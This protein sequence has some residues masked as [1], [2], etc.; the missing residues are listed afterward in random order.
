MSASS[1]SCSA[2]AKLVRSRATD[3]AYVDMRYGNGFAVGWKG[4]HAA[5]RRPVANTGESSHL[6]G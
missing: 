3:I 4:A 5:R 6:N 1:A 2:A